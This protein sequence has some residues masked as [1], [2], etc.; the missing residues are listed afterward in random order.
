MVWVEGEISNFSAPRSGHLYFTLKDAE[1]Q[2][3]AVMFRSQA[4]RLKFAPHDGLMVRARGRLLDLRGAGQVPALRRRARAGRARRAAA[5]LRA[6]QEE[7]R[8]RGAVRSRRASGRCRRGRG[9]SASSRH[10]RARRCA[11]SCASPSG[12]GAMRFLIVALPGA[13]RRRRRSRSFAR[14]AASSAPTSTSIIV[15]A[16]RRLG[17]GSGGVQRR[18]AG[19]RDRGLPRAG[20]ERGRARGRL[21][22]RRLRRRRARAD[23]VGARPS[24]WC[25]TSPT[26]SIG[27]TRRATRLT[28]RRHAR[29]RR[30]AAAHRQ[31]GQSRGAG[32]AHAGVARR[33]RALDGDHKRLAALHPRARLHRDRAALVE[34]QPGCTRI[35]RG[36]SIARARA[37]SLRQA[38]ERARA[39]RSRS[40]G[41]L[42]HRRRQAG[43]DVA[44]RRCSSAA[45]R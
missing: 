12:A 42:R 18:G 29:G 14:C 26:L 7:A 22:H 32:A 17:R 44:A 45:T 4:E 25:R 1:A 15:G 10:R 27:S 40:G 13:G 11:T 30:G 6:A 2:L 35:R 24:W 33:R 16:R 20:G 21:H 43:G 38:L 31:R 19:A 9:A 8:R 23:A 37:R 39:P 3:P 28:A 36:C 5:R 41:A 34:L